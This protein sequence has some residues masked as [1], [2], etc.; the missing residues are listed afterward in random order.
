[1]AAV[2]VAALVVVRAW[3]FR[4]DPRP[5]AEHRAIDMDVGKA[6]EHLAAAIRFPTVS[7][8]DGAVAAEAF[9]GLRAWLEATYPAVHR[10]LARE[11]VAGHTLVYSGR[12]ARRRCLR[13]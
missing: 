1:M 6:A 11:L 12:G 8:E 13:P 3:R 4:P 10:V 7:R 2:G 9:A 5:P